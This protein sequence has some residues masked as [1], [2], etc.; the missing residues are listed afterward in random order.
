M[1]VL[2]ALS[3]IWVDASVRAHRDFRLTLVDVGHGQAALVEVPTGETVLFD[4]GTEGGGRARAQALAEVLWSRHVDRIDALC[5]SHMNED[6][7]DFLPYL[8]RRFDIGKV[9]V[10]QASELNDLGRTVRAWAHAHGLE[11][12]TV[13]EG[14]VLR[15][16]ALTCDVLHPSA[17]FVTGTTVGENSKSLV[18]LCRYGGLTF[19]L[20]GDIEDDAIRRLCREYGSRLRTDV[21][22]LPHHGSY[23]PAMDG[24]VRL[25]APRIALASEP[26][27]GVPAATEALLRTRGIPLW[28]TGREGAIIIT[29]RGGRGHVLGWKSGRTM[30]FEP[31]PVERSTDG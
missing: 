16:G 22:V 10:P 26:A 24:F 14:D 2:L 28:I 4:A 18:L 6:H 12:Q 15:A 23:V 25:V 31:T 8:A 27:D 11:L 29:F 3:Y 17:R 9:V 7:V 21:L 20:P 19:L 30:D 5:V 13:G 1:A